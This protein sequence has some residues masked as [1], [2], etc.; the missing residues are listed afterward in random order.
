M[1]KKDN[2]KIRKMFIVAD[3]VSLRVCTKNIYFFTLKN[4]AYLNLC[5]WASTVE[6]I[7]ILKHLNI[8][9]NLA[10]FPIFHFEFTKSQLP[11][12]FVKCS[13]IAL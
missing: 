3:L 8:H 12:C 7:G 5:L 11:S 4:S 6:A 9:L 10:V 13:S 2:K 1:I